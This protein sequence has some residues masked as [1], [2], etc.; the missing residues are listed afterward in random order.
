MY[1]YN[2]HIIKD[3]K[4]EFVFPCDF[5]NLSKKQKLLFI[6]N[7]LVK[8]SISKSIKQ[9]KKN[10]LLEMCSDWILYLKEKKEVKTLEDAPYHKY[11]IK[12]K[13]K[14]SEQISHTYN[15][16]SD[17]YF[18][19]VSSPD[20]F[21]NIREIFSTNE[22]IKYTEEYQ[23]ELENI[24][25]DFYKLSINRLAN[26]NTQYQGKIIHY[27]DVFKLA[28]N[29]FDRSKIARELLGKNKIDPSENIKIK[30][31]LQNITAKLSPHL[32]NLKKRYDNIRTT[33]QDQS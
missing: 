19:E 12:T 17:I 10:K 30:K 14:S 2:P 5:L 20:D 8:I 27:V 32:K 7:L 13:T 6:D 21:F 28:L 29:G 22:D 3:I 31:I 16:Q 11:P 15:P 25:D 18:K 24:I 1:E 9:T 23:E 4:S 33:M 26:Y